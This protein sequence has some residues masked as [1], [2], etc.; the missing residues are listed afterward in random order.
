MGDWIEQLAA[1]GRCARPHR[2]AARARGRGRADVPDAAAVSPARWCARWWSVIP[3]HVQYFTPREHR[4]AARA[5]RSAVRHVGTRPEGVLRCATTFERIGG[6]RRRCRGCSCAATRGRGASPDRMW[7]PDFRDRMLVIAAP[8]GLTGRRARG[9]FGTFAPGMSA[10]TMWGA[11]VWFVAI[12]GA[13]LVLPKVVHRELATGA[14]PT[15]APAVLAYALLATLALIAAHVVPAALGVL[16]PHSVLATAAA[17]PGAAL[18][19]PRRPAGSAETPRR[20]LGRPPRGHAVA[21]AGARPRWP[22][23]SS[24]SSRR[25]RPVVRACR[26][27]HRRAETSTSPDVAGWLRTGTL[28]Q[29]D[30][31]SPTRQRQLPEQRQRRACSARCCRGTPTSSCAS[32]GCRPGAERVGVYALAR[33]LRA[34]RT[35]PRSSARPSWRSPP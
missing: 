12:W 8:A 1:P 3:T 10:G 34:P 22:S 14:K 9:R 26:R 13:S 2:R 16:R 33:E 27:R 23:C 11:F 29:V 15:G 18:L 25:L 30:Q 21:R 19:V 20:R 7:A 24:P 4:R 6:T 32:S 35:A 17:L 31:F 28:W 5:P